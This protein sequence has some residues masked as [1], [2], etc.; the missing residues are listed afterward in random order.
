[1]QLHLIYLL[2]SLFSLSTEQR[3]TRQSWRCSGINLL[4]GSE[5]LNSLTSTRWQSWLQSS[6]A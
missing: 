3:T 6:L 4:L 1:M 2:L 5:S